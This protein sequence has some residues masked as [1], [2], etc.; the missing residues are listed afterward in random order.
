M[1]D[2]GTLIDFR[3]ADIAG[4]RPV[5]DVV[6]GGLS[7]GGL[8]R[9][10]AGTALFNGEIS[11]ANRGGFASVRAAVGPLDLSAFRGLAVRVRGDGRTW[12]L[13]LRPDDDGDG[14]AWRALFP[15]TADQWTEA[16]LPFTDFAPVFRGHAV[17]GAPP[18]DPRRLGQVGFMVSGG[19]AGAFSLELAWVRAWNAGAMEP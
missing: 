2:Q 15:T 1:D 6:M 8:V 16:R 19:P 11:L 12:Q 7:R 17:P 14:V 13:R 10:E 18:F 4:W 3:T 9:T 5:H